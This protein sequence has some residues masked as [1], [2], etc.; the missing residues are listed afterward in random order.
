[1]TTKTEQYIRDAVDAAKRELAGNRIS[2]T[3][4]TMHME[5]DGA[6][7]ILAE[8]MKAQAEANEANSIAMLELAKSLKPKDACAVRIESTPHENNL[9]AQSS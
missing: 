5:A 9:A 6:T 2:D 8:A 1:M 7:Q 3:N 4:I